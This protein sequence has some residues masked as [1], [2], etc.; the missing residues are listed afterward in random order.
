MAAV[1][2]IVELSNDLK[3]AGTTVSKNTI[4]NTLC[5]N[6]LKVCS[7]RKVPLFKKAHLQTCTKVA[8]E[9]LNDLPEKAWEKCCCQTQI[10]LKLFSINS[11]RHVWRKRNYEYDP[12]N[13]ISTVKQGGGNISKGT[14]QL[15]CIEGS[16]D[17]TMYHKISD[18]NL[19][20]VR[21]LNMG[22]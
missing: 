5:R 20:S 15:Y 22:N 19:L 6:V 12:K 13:T 17:G 14:G 8:S 2:V 1:G 10:S 4:T 21:I 16:M 7:S 9:H 11:T 18:K 3:G